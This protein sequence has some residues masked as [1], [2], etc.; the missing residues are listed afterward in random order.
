MEN[1]TS[2][3]TCPYCGQK[4]GKR[5]GK[6]NN[7]KEVC[8]LCGSY[9]EMYCEYIHDSDWAIINSTPNNRSIDFNDEEGGKD[10]E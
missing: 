10:D 4:G 3:Y 7:G 6:A 9:D 2:L 5:L 1:N 8:S